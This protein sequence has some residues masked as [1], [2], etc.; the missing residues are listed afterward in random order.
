MQK[1][2]PHSISSFTTTANQ[3]GFLDTPL[4]GSTTAKATLH[5][6]KAPSAIPNSSPPEASPSSTSK[7]VKLLS[8]QKGTSSGKSTYVWPAAAYIAER[9]CLLSHPVPPP[10]KRTY[11]QAVTKPVTPTNA[12][13]VSKIAMLACA[14]PVPS[15]NKIASLLR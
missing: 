15:P 9:Q 14:L 12:S 8:F 2:L 11:S 5:N 4:Y 3:E 7:V 13:T 1:E 10:K 6:A